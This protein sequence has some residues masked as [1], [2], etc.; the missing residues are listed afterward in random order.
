M[1]SQQDQQCRGR[2]RLSLVWN[3]TQCAIKM[4]RGTVLCAVW[5]SGRSTAI[6]DKTGQRSG[7][8][9][10]SPED[11]GLLAVV[12]ADD[13]GLCVGQAPSALSRMWGAC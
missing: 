12:I 11:L 3:I 2:S 9:S 13:P 4:R 8:E 7:Y 10:L 1:K 6:K 5:M